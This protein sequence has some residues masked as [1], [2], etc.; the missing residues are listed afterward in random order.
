MS[1]R[2]TL[3]EFLR[4]H[5]DLTVLDYAPENYTV[6]KAP[7]LFVTPEMSIEWG[8]SFGLYKADMALALVVPFEDFRR[9]EDALDSHITDV[10]DALDGLPA[11]TGTATRVVFDDKKH[12]YEIKLSLLVKKESA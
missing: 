3:V 12:G 4:E 7:T 5:T 11:S 9:S 8:E 10:L 6:V 1:A 2:S